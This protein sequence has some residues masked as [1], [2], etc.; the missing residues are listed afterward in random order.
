MSDPSA[1]RNPVDVLAEEFAERVRRGE[2]PSVE[3]YVERHPQWGGQIRE[4]FPALLVM[5]KLKPAAGDPTGPFAADRTEDLPALRLERLGEYRIVREIGRGGMGVVYEAVQ[6]SLGRHVALKVLPGTGPA[7]ATYLER[8][9]R[10]ARAAGQLQHPNI[11]PVYGVGEAE[12]V[13][14]YA[15][16]YVQG[17]GLDVVLSDLRRLHGRAGDPVPL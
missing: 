10:E 8:F 12:G 15:M 5:E 7:N 4:L 1:E 11:V 17:Q 9:R 6:E 2:R 14:F 3:E 13:H 16:Q